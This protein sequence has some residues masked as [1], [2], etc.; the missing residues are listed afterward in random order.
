MTVKKNKIQRI[1]IPFNQVLG[2]V[3]PYAKNRFV[4]QIKAV[5]LI[6]AYLIV[7]QIWVLG[8]PIAQA[9]IIAIGMSLVVFG[10]TFFMEGL[11]IGLMPLGEVIGIKLPQKSKLA[12]IMIFSFILGVGVTFAEPAIGVLKVAG[13]SVKAWDA[14]L[15]FLMLNKFSN[16][17]VLAV[18][19]GVGIAV[20]FGMLRFL[21]NWS[22]KPF[23]YVLVFVLT[24]L[25]VW[26][27]FEPNM[28]YL[29]GLAWDCGA[30]TTGPVTVPLVLALGIGISRIVSKSSSGASGFGV[31]TLAS[32]FPILTVLLLGISLLGFVPKPLNETDFF[33]SLN[34]N[35][36]S[37]L[38]A[39]KEQMTGYAL[40][41]AGT[42]AQLEL[43]DGNK[44]G[45]LD[46]IKKMSADPDLQNKIL[47][48]APNAFEKWIMTKASDEQR[49]AVYKDK[50]SVKKALE[51]YLSK[52]S[53]NI[54]PG[55][56]LTR[57]SLSAVQAILPL[58]VFLILV[59]LFVLRERIP[60]FDEISLGIL[61]ALIGMT[62]FNIGIELGLSKLGNQVGEKL[63]S[64]FKAIEL[65]EQKK[66]IRN[67][68]TNLIQ[69]AITPDG[70]TFQFFYT[71]FNNDYKPLPFDRSKLDAASLQYSYTPKRGPLFG[72]EG[73]L[74]G[75]LVVLLFGFIMG[76]GATLAEPAL[77]AL[78]IKV[79]ELTVGTFK[80]TLLMQAV[81]LGVGAGIALGV[82]KIIW[83]IPLIWMIAPPYLLLLL[84]TRISS[85]EF[86][87]I[88]WDSAGVTTGP[89]TV[90]LV[91]AMGLGISGQVGA[92]EGFGI[93]AMASVMP[94][95]AVL[96][97]GL[98]VNAQR[99]KALSENT[100]SEATI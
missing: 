54:E 22:L 9:G 69:T 63:P 62:L 13:S 40:W 58:S 59:L 44:A 95:L 100:T 18:A 89:I 92:I 3:W 84:I 57:N 73:G 34:R 39:N 45:M 53:I 97:V 99:K 30:V 49:L 87:N 94:I 10:L 31:V 78:G 75:I 20:V 90:P 36:V 26:A 24:G 65:S 7:F 82:A 68:D 11:L 67:F 38:F 79:E 55:D 93:L 86:V 15:L 19:V 91:L 33:N 71:K 48:P 56:V 21:Y 88:G 42:P 72:K 32:A 41:N 23:I 37:N 66:I 28:I 60:R 61:F 4:D 80:K 81:A 50:D 16:Y 46:Y 1:K 2:L 8:I 98:Y 96:T 5:W 85:E 77:N 29:T 25:S 6:I 51:L 14:P 74:L 12:V 35:K 17:L 27:F 70:E 83:N 76:Y 47:G 52:Q 43:F 64:S